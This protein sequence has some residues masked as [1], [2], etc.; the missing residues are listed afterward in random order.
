MELLLL[1]VLVT[2][3]TIGWLAR[4]LVGKFEEAH[5]DDRWSTPS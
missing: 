1:L 4:E 3:I 2:G 5:P